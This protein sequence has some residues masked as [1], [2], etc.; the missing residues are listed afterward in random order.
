MCDQSKFY[1]TL[2]FYKND[3]R[4]H[5]PGIFLNSESSIHFPGQPLPTVAE[6]GHALLIF[7]IAFL[8]LRSK[9]FL[10][11]TWFC[12]KNLDYFFTNL[13]HSLK[14]RFIIHKPLFNIPNA[15]E[16]RNI[17][18]SFLWTQPRFHEPTFIFRSKFYISNQ[19]SFSHIFMT[20]SD[21]NIAGITN[22]KST[23]VPLG[24]SVLCVLSSL[25]VYLNFNTLASY[26]IFGSCN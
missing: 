6:K 17:A 14:A 7:T 20:G 11:Q 18:A 10:L 15:I 5:E 9:L 13:V 21:T 1:C 16:N 26:F 25:M 23:R 8:F 3:I 24:V 2:F 22:V 12:F 19:L 4:N